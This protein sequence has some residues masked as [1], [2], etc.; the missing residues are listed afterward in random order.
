MTITQFS[1]LLVEMLGINN[2]DKID[3]RVVL[4]MADAYR[5]ALLTGDVI[6][7]DYVKYFKVTIKNDFRGKYIDLPCDLCPVQNNGAFRFVGGDD[8]EVNY[9]Y[10]HQKKFRCS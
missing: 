8:D 9:R 3:D 6:T 5:G 4:A 2:H 7:G 1:E 10:L